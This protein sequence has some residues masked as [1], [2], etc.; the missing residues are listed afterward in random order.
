MQKAIYLGIHEAVRNML[1]NPVPFI[2]VKGLRK[3]AKDMKKWPVKL[4]E[5]KARFYLIQFVRSAEEFGTGGAAFRYMYGA[6]LKESA[7]LLKNDLILKASTQMGEIATLWRDLAYRSSRFIKN[8]E[9]SHE[10][11]TILS[12]I[13]QECAAGEERIFKGLAKLNA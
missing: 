6:F 1:K 4:P 12:E 8:R 5:D 2:G 3:L 9:E 13:L 11:Y 10:S 7:E